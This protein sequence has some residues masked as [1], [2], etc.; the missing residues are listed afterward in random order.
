MALE[1][2]TDLSSATEIS[3]GDFSSP[4]CLTFDGR[5]GGDK[6][7]KI[8]IVNDESSSST[9]NIS[10]T[11]ISSDDPYRVFLKN[12]TATVWTEMLYDDSA[13]VDNIVIEANGNNYFFMKVT[14][15]PD[16]QISNFQNL[17]VHLVDA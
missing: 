9:V 12:S 3:S 15:T 4:L 8:Y 16:T 17:K 10:V 14:I 13:S 2:K 5:I 1:L 7:Q 6:E 11:G